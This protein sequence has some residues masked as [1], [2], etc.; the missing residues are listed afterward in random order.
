MILPG[1]IPIVLQMDSARG[2]FELPAKIFTTFQYWLGKFNFTADHPATGP[3]N[4]NKETP[5]K[6]IQTN[7][8]IFYELSALCLSKR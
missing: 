1:S 5:I 7:V 6:R 8:N 3:K 4:N 2:W